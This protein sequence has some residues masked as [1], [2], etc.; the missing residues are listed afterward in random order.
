[1]NQGREGKLPYIEVKAVDRRF[2]DKEVAARLI[3][4]L[5]DAACSVFGEDA[6]AQIWV[7][8]DGVPASRFGIGGRALG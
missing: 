8:V 4:A 1:V 2:E 3:A 5:T 6:R 7:V